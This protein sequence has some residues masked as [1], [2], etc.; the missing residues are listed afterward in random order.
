MADPIPT[1]PTAAFTRIGTPTPRYD[2]RLKVTGGARYA[3][4]QS[5]ANPAF[6]YLVVSSIAKG[7]IGSIDEHAARAVPGVLDV[8]TFRNIG[9]IEPGKTFSQKGYMGT[10]IAPMQQNILHDGQIVALVA[11]DTYEAAREAARRLQVTYVEDKPSAT[12][13]SAGLKSGP[14]EP[15]PAEAPEDPKVGNF[16]A[17]FAQAAV[18]VDARY[19]TPTQHHNPIELFTTTCAWNNG[20]LTVWEGS[21]NVSGMKHGLA[22]QIGISPDDIHIISPY[23]GGAF[24]SKGSLTQRTAIVALAA[25]KLKR[26]LKLEA[27]RAQGFTI[28]TYRAETRHH[29]Q[30]GA[31]PD[32]K[33]VALNHEGE[34]ISSRPDDYKVGGTDATTRLY[35]CAN[36]S[37]KVTIV[38]ADRNTPGF[39]RSPPEVP[40]VFALECAMDE[41]AFALK[42]DPVELRRVNDTMKE[43]IKGLPYT[44]RQLMPCFDAAAQAFGWSQR[45]PQPGSMRDGDW[46]IGYGCASTLYPTQI[47]P[48]TARVRLTPQGGATVQTGTHEIG[49]GAYTVVAIT[50]SDKLGVPISSIDVRVG[51]SELPPAPVAGG[52]NSTA[53]VCNVVAKA[54]EQI[55][56]RLA[57]A[58]VAADD[59]PL[60]GADPKTLVLADGS[61]RAP[62]G[63]AEPLAKAM[64]RATSGAI[65]EYTENLPKGAKPDSVA[66]L[67]KGVSSIGGGFKGKEHVQAAF[68]ASFVEVRVH[69]QTCEIRTPRVV[70][71]YAFGRVMNPMAARSQLMGAQIWGV[72]AALHEATEIDRRAAR[73]TNTDL[74]E[75][76]IPVNADIPSYQAIILPENDTQVND[77]GIKGVGE[78]ANVGMNAA[79]A[80]AVFH[81]TGVRVRELPVRLEKLLG[82]RFLKA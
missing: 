9:P 62:D 44:S 64:A 57:V 20:Q 32:G 38:H 28:A 79:V 27:T 1:P 36:V 6:G 52:S 15:P 55:R 80:N 29:V 13:G 82:S 43:P 24:G 17:A 75:Y 10:S 23:I 67:Y 78:L 16:A 14:V 48:A 47:A 35:A 63:R 25:R 45:N 19:V 11:A 61:L 5:V 30:L 73:Y 7:R 31:A 58:A 71:A 65:E 26:P 77:L 12:F 8:F 56:A 59:S 60:R 68:G 49:N 3:S 50:A 22:L 37:S 41:L 42:M 74:A 66:M 51:D 53:S 70:G 81:A 2:G 18:K 76:L 4:D 72:S 69:A 46:L 39:M 21:Q 34:E 54:C 33:L 40:Y